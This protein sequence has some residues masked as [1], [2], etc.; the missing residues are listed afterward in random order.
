MEA[1]RFR[2]ADI[3]KALLEAGAGPSVSNDDGVSALEM[4]IREGSVE[5]AEMLNSAGLGDE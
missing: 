1:I 3:A 4:A 2:D 5:R